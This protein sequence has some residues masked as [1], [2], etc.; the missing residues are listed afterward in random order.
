MWFELGL[1]ADDGCHTVHVFNSKSLIQELTLRF[2]TQHKPDRNRTTITMNTAL[3]EVQ[4]DLREKAKLINTEELMQ[5]CDLLDR[6]V[7]ATDVIIEMKA[8][9]PRS[10]LEDLGGLMSDADEKVETTPSDHILYRH[11]STFGALGTAFAWVFEDKPLSA[12]SKAK[13]VIKS[14]VGKLRDKGSTHEEFA[15][16]ADKFLD[17]L[18]VYVKENHA[19]PL[20]WEEE[21]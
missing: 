12:V 19:E 8:P 13:E 20:V 2:K 21:E 6:M 7:Q 16:A 14:H 10:A 3:V 17:T 9:R 1:V 5:A 18:E 11:L 15:D 4:K